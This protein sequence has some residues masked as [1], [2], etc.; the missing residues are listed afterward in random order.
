MHSQNDFFFFLEQRR[1]MKIGKGKKKPS[2]FIIM[3]LL[4]C[5]TQFIANSL[6]FCITCHF[7]CPMLNRKCYKNV[8]PHSERFRYLTIK[9]ETVTHVTL[10]LLSWNMYLWMILFLDQFCSCIISSYGCWDSSITSSCRGLHFIV[11]VTS[12]LSLHLPTSYFHLASSL[13]ILFYIVIYHV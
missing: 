10:V 1:K 5:K 4:L 7:R 12:C 13:L 2:I 8:C 6:L 11:S 9:W 3:Q